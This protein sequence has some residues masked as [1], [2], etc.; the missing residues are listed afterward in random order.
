M[1]R[2]DSLPARTST[3][4]IYGAFWR[5]HFYAGLLVMPVL[6][7]LAL[8][9]G[10]YLFKD[11]IEAAMRHRLLTVEPGAAVLAPQAWANAAKA[12][13]PGRV[14]ALTPPADAARSAQV[15]V[16]T[17]SGVAHTVYVDPHTGHVLGAIDGGGLMQVVKR[18]HSLDLAGPV[19][20]LLVE[21]VA[22]WAI[23]MVVTGIVLWWPRGQA[24]GVFRVRGRPRQ[25]L[26]WRDLHAVTGIFAGAVIIFLAATGMPWSAV[27]G[28]EVRRFTTEAGW[29]RPAA[30][31]TDVGEHAGH[32]LSATAV[33][34]AL[35]DHVMADMPGMDHGEP[36]T[37]N[38]AVAAADAAGLPR[39]YTLSI[40]ARANQAWTASYIPA[41]AE[42]MRTLY[43]SPSSGAVLA[44]VGYDGFGPAAKAIEWGI[45]VHQGKQFGL[46]NKL[47]MLA[48]CV[49]IW[50]LAFSALV[51]WWKRRPQGGL[52]AP[53]K[54]ASRR[55]Y[56]A[57]AAVVIPLGIIYPLVGA[58]LG[59]V[60]VLDLC[61]R[62]AAASLRP[63]GEVLP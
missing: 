45:A 2:S 53:P 22:G 30:P 61:I 34:W 35:Q 1:S 20:N 46:V 16:A 56:V 27:W 52:G 29:G 43:L 48:G 5:W 59:V 7:L 50:T 15:T 37:L 31:S 42:A 11:E 10:L 19:A 24:G 41:K 28:K 49:A 3:S 47:V 44:D 36:L 58:S 23:V 39:P 18:L 12:V 17:P 8:T 54:P 4:A 26:F 40:P 14:T 32:A 63:R 57:L 6:M 51:M 60:L 38:T 13:Y 9:G 55:T 62:H 25:R 21:V 33:P